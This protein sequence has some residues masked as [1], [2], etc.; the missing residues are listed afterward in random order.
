MGRRAYEFEEQDFHDTVD[1][2]VREQ[3][4]NTKQFEST[5][6][7]LLG[8]SQPNKKAADDAMLNLRN[9]Y[10]ELKDLEKRLDK[11]LDSAYQ[12]YLKKFKKGE[13]HLTKKEFMTKKK[14]A[15][16]YSEYI[17]DINAIETQKIAL[18]NAHN[19][20]TEMVTACKALHD[21][22][23]SP[24]GFRNLFKALGNAFTVSGDMSMAAQVSI[25]EVELRASPKEGVDNRKFK[26]KV[27]DFLIKAIAALGQFIGNLAVKMR[28]YAHNTGYKAPDEHGQGGKP[29]YRD[30]VHQNIQ[31]KFKRNKP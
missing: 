22:T 20:L 9:A 7:F 1:R 28:A 19:A 15:S 3:D 13:K 23:P 5:L 12:S 31:N 6:A 14:Q 2:V 18:K 17:E 30:E 27:G 4:R 21:Q 29:G 16:V 25:M 11:S 8:K 26:E 24:K 10:T